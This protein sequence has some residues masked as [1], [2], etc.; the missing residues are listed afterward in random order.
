MK[1]QV[2]RTLGALFLASSIVVAA[3]PTRSY[4]GGQAEAA[5]SG[6]DPTPSQKYLM[7]YDTSDVTV[8]SGIYSA[9]AGNSAA[10]YEYD[11]SDYTK[12]SSASVPIV[13]STA[14]I[15]T[16]GDSMFQFAYVDNNGR[17]T[18]ADGKNAVIL[19]FNYTGNLDGGV[20]TIPSTMEAYSQYTDSAGSGG[21]YCAVSKT[22]YFLF[23]RTVETTYETQ[24]T[25][26]EDDQGFHIWY[27]DENGARVET[28][29]PEEGD[30]DPAD[31]KMY[32][33]ERDSAQVEVGSKISFLQC[34]YA[35]KA[36][37]EGIDDSNL[38]YFNT[39]DRRPDDTVLYTFSAQPGKYFVDEAGTVELSVDL[40]RNPATT[41]DIIATEGAYVTRTISQ[42][43]WRIKD[44]KVAYIGNQ[45]LTATADGWTV[46]PTLISDGNGTSNGVFANKR[47]IA[48]LNLPNSISGIGNYAFYGC[49]NLG[50]ISFGNGLTD[51]GNHA[52]D[53]CTSL[54]T[55]SIPSNTQLATIGSFAFSECRSLQNITLPIAVDTICDGAFYGCLNLENC[56]IT[57]GN[58][59]AALLKRLGYYVFQGD[60]TLSGIVLP[61]GFT[62]N[63][64]AS[65]FEGCRALRYIQVNN[66]NVDIVPS[67]AGSGSGR[68]F[69]LT[70][71]NSLQAQLA[72]TFYFEG[73]GTSDANGNDNGSPM[74]SL[75]VTARNNE[76]A[77][78]FLDIDIY[79]KTVTDNS[80]GAGG[81]VI[82]RVNSNNQL[83]KSDFLNT[84][85]DVKVLTFP[86]YIGPYH[87]DELGAGTFQD[88][89]TLTKVTLPANIN[90]I[91]DRTFMGCHNL[92]YVIFENDQVAIG[93]DAFKTQDVSTHMSG[94]AGHG[95]CPDGGTVVTNAD[96]TP[97]V[98]LCFVG[99]ISAD[100]TPF[101]YAMNVN[102]GTYNNSSQTRS[103]AKFNS[104]WPKCL[105]V[106]FNYDTDTGIGFPEVTD[107]PT[108]ATLGD[109]A[110]KE[111]LS[112]TQKNAAV[113]V[114]AALTDPSIRLTQDQEDFRNAARTLEIP[115]GVLGIKNG[116]F[117]TNTT[118]GIAPE[119]ERY[120]SV[121]VDGI[122]DFETDSIVFDNRS[123]FDTAL[124]SAGAAM[125]AGTTFARGTGTGANLALGTAGY[126]PDEEH[127]SYVQIDAANS[128]F[129]GCKYLQSIAFT[130]SGTK[131]LEPFDFYGCDGLETVSATAPISE[132]PERAFGNCQNL[133]T[134]ELYSAVPTIGE[135]AFEND[136]SLANVY[137]AQGLT[138]LG[139]AAF[140]GCEN[141]QM[142]DFANS[143]YFTCRDSIIFSLQPYTVNEVLGG[144]SNKYVTS[145]E[146]EG[147]EAIAPESFAGSS[148]R[149]VDLT[150]SAIT[151]VPSFAFKD[152]QSLSQ[153]MLPDTCIAINDYAF[154]DSSMDYLQASQYLEYIGDHAF[155]HILT[156]GYP[157]ADHS[158][159]KDVTISAP[160][161]SKLATYADFY[162]YSYTAKKAPTYYYVYFYDYTDDSPTST[163][164]VDTQ[165]V[166]AG[167]SA[168]APE[169]HGRQ[170]YKFTGWSSDYT[171][172]TENV[173]TIAQYEY[174]YSYGRLP[175]HFIDDD[176]VTEFSW[177][178]LYVSYG[179]SAVDLDGIQTPTKEGY[180]F[181]KWYPD[182][183]LNSIKAETY[184]YATYIPAT[185]WPVT[186]YTADYRQI[187]VLNVPEGEWAPTYVDGI[188][189]IE[190][191]TFTG[192]DTLPQQVFSAISAVAQ[193]KDNNSASNT[194]TVTYYTRDYT[195]ITTLQ[196]ADGDWAPTK[197]DG[198]PEIPGYV[199][200]GWDTLPAKVT[201]DM[202]AVAQYEAEAEVVHDPPYTVTF[203]YYNS[204]EI[205]DQIT[206]VEKHADLS[207][208]A[209]PVR[210]GYT[211]IGWD[212]AGLANVQK[213][214][215]TWPLY[216]SELNEYTVNYYT[217]DGSELF[218]T[219][220]V[221]EGDTAPNI[222]GPERTGYTF[223]GWDRPL[224]GIRENVNTRA[225]YVSDSSLIGKCTV[226]YFTADGSTLYYTATV[227]AGTDAPFIQGPPIEGYTFV[228][229][230]RPL[231]NVLTSFDT[232]ATY[233][234][235]ASTKPE[236][237]NKTLY[238][239]TVVN[240]SG[241]GSYAAGTQVIVVANDPASGLQFGSWTISPENTP[242]TSKA[243]SATVITMPEGPVTVKA[244]YVAK[245]GGGS[246]GGTGGGS[247]SSGNNG[248]SGGSSGSGSVVPTRST[249]TTV[250]IDKN[251]LSNTGVVSATVNGSSDNFTIKITESTTA[252]EEVTRALLAHFG[253]L[254][255]VVYFPMDISLYDAS[256][257]K[258]ITDTS[259]L[260]V[261]I[262]L[263]LPDSM[264]QYG[265]NNK[266]AGIVNGQIDSLSP[267]FTTISNVPCVTFT[268]THFSPYV[269]YVN[270]V[271]MTAGGDLPRYDVTPKT[272]DGIHPKWFASIALFAVSI[273]LFLKK[274]KK[275]A[276]KAK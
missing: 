132:I 163:V 87:I 192:W 21:G 93:T 186:Y 248:R 30:I 2:R 189:E 165:K 159:N 221:K 154:D 78:K 172:V 251:G 31:G 200:T 112:E 263:P 267:K 242:I 246:S 151:T 275:V 83:L 220:T 174:D 222:Q 48:T 253:D 122:V 124:T 262:T 15:Y 96:N 86:N 273:V 36:N 211:F 265:G 197:V 26:R 104:G 256:G 22:G 181:D 235:A 16:T 237:G 145:D 52:F 168:T 210:E 98:E 134:V 128:D 241:S 169:P 70:G 191:F 77:Y 79:E 247:G 179:D 142:V 14:P 177:S 160:E 57:G 193:Y 92:H 239:L 65:A 51:I 147:V 89:C 49:A 63:V 108:R 46:N 150:S 148:V 73:P 250:V 94:T 258:K 101:M 61:V 144:R 20:L 136:A 217:W 146:L 216:S 4:E 201:E 164:L 233:I 58:K 118:S 42:E 226:N 213:D 138:T 60:E 29:D 254:T 114:L 99:T 266:V 120:M 11:G 23:Y 236:E 176:G 105:E 88:K 135:H 245:T 198:I 7:G 184:V 32:R 117:Y 227:E 234:P 171:N 81:Q 204:T 115:S 190:G 187:T 64:E 173:Y 207:D 67:A 85:G 156:T 44:A 223:A 40:D 41:S 76:F 39:V 195:V 62:E 35:D 170:D 175:V 131:S 141:L 228:G 243:L 205:F 74:G 82:F 149:S 43:D 95:A 133:E 224:T 68:D 47:N 178:P 72:E 113:Q 90:R 137:I 121:I 18:S 102:T 50:E 276:V 28:T 3:I 194:H 119:D 56:D 66:R 259:G 13:E 75:H 84:N 8:K 19:G 126:E 272:G 1:K 260:T 229:W 225:L 9:T 71:D 59:N 111:Y 268:A 103:F 38:Y 206:N 109:Y 139:P 10:V 252:S 180:A 161:N 107:F 209:G 153:V 100:S 106:Q 274:D 264:I 130:G 270:T 214:I 249:G 25:K 140:V 69:P 54:N 125:G 155:D 45:S 271:E 33:V 37:W 166:E 261:T 244:N 80:A 17:A 162:G 55:V 6:V 127:A 182:G 188:P 158:N 129:A 231:T 123:D 269:I 219:T 143:E 199:F 232:R 91:G 212:N 240:G 230:D 208:H 53:N 218:Y 116:L 97:A 255:N 202:Q 5:Q 167:Q 183:T 185:T 203:Y 238:P 34:Y 27:L 24:Y 196:V 157:T 152:A 110:T 12:I 215:D 257:T